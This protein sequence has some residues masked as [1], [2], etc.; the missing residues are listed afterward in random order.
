MLII[1]FSISCSKSTKS[2]DVL[3]PNKVNEDGKAEGSWLWYIVHT[4]FDEQELLPVNGDPGLLKTSFIGLEMSNGEVVPGSK[5]RLYSLDS[6]LL[7]EGSIVQYEES[8]K[9]DDPFSFVMRSSPN[10]PPPYRHFRL[11]GSV[12]K[13]N[14]QEEI[15]DTIELEAD[16]INDKAIELALLVIA[17][18]KNDPNRA[19][20]F[21]RLELELMDSLQANY[22]IYLRAKDARLLD[23]VLDA[24][25]R[26]DSRINTLNTGNND[27]NDE[28]QITISSDDIG[29]EVENDS[30]LW[31]T[32]RRCNRSFYKG[33][34]FDAMMSF[35]E[36]RPYKPGTGWVLKMTRDYCEGVKQ[37]PGAGE[38]CS[39][40]CALEFCRLL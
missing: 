34:E 36:G 21:S 15:V 19:D 11:I 9:E 22:G 17:V 1:T 6:S 27:P 23:D 4:G 16:Y 3:Y 13:Y 25:V 38:F 39:E 10:A 31:G 26:A 40:T 18:S 20:Y 8:G 7:Y 5:A 32:C 24:I 28:I 12:Y 29:Q 2:L 14:S 35:A 30:H 33:S 37:D